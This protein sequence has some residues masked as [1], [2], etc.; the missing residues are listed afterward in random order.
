LDESRFD[1]EGRR[2]DDDGRGRG[3]VEIHQSTD[4]QAAAWFDPGDPN[5]SVPWFAGSVPVAFLHGQPAGRYYFAATFVS[6]G[7]EFTITLE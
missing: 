5:Y 4:C 7:L 2:E 6:P 3:H 1:C